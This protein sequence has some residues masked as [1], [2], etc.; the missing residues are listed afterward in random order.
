[1]NFEMYTCTLLPDVTRDD[2][3]KLGVRGNASGVKAAF[4]EERDR[5]LFMAAPA[6]LSALEELAYCFTHPDMQN[7]FALSAC[8]EALE[9]ATKAI[10]KAAGQ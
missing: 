8:A 2:P 9:R 10:A 1:M 3:P 6:L 7:A 4:W 5:A